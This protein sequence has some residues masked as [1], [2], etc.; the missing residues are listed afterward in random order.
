MLSAQEQTVTGV[1][2]VTESGATPWIREFIRQAA[3]KGWQVTQ[4]APCDTRNVPPEMLVVVQV[5][6]LGESDLD[7]IVAEIRDTNAD[8]TIL[9]TAAAPTK[10]VARLCLRHALPI[11]FGYELAMYVQQHFAPVYA[12]ISVTPQAKLAASDST[13]WQ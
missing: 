11:A 12:T 7:A 4:S 5:D 6:E 3:R 9:V 10:P 13:S 1:H 2:I 8:R